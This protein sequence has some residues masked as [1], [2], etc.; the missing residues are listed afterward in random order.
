MAD[1]LM[2]ARG[3]LGIEMPL[4]TLPAV[5]KRLILAA[6]RR[7]VPVIVATQVLESMRDRAAADPRRSHRCRPCR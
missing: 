1:G 6:R 2:V 5:Q 3:D 7:G 4:E